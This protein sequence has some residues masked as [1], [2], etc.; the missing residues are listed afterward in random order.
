MQ[1]DFETYLWDMHQAGVDI[2]R[3]TS[4]KC[5]EEYLG[6]RDLR[7]I[8]ERNFEIIGEAIAQCRLRHPEQ[9]NSVGET[10]KI[11][12]FRNRLAHAYHS[13]DDSFVWTVVQVNL[14]PLIAE[15]AA[16]LDKWHQP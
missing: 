1:R 13:I 10:E 9:I 5:E 4:G 2:L 15:V 6:D 16:L 12:A 8:V 3:V 7:R 14:T 11:V